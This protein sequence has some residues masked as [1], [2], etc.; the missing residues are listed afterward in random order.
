MSKLKNLFQKF[1]SLHDMI[2]LSIQK[3]NNNIFL[4]KQ[5]EFPLKL[6]KDERFVID[7]KINLDEFSFTKID[8][9]FSKIIN[10]NGKNYYLKEEYLTMFLYNNYLFFSLSPKNVKN[11]SIN[12][13]KKENLYTIKYMFY[14][15]YINLINDC[16]QNSLFIIFDENEY[17]Y[18]I[19]IKFTDR[20]LLNK[21]KNIFINGINNSII[22][23]YSSVSSFINSQIVEYYKD[24]FK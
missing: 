12:S 23:E 22:L 13:I 14:L 3:I 1:I 10:K 6:I 8:V 9:S 11:F 5:I 7:G 24:A 19:L 15:R 2:S 4:F 18:N 17:N 20:I 16:D 21:A